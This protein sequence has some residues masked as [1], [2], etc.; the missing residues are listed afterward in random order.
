VAEMVEAKFAD[1]KLDGYRYDD[2]PED[3]QTWRFV[4][5]GLDVNRTPAAPGSRSP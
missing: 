4:L 3:G 5:R 1:G 2:M